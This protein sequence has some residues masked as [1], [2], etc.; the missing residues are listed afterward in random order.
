M[1]VRELHD[2]RPVAM[3]SR[4]V[5]A[6]D[7]PEFHR[8]IYL[9]EVAVFAPHMYRRDGRVMTDL[10]QCDFVLPE[11][12]LVSLSQ[13][14]IERLLHLSRVM[15][16]THRIRHHQFK[17]LQSGCVVFLGNGCCF[18]QV[19]RCHFHHH[20][21][22]LEKRLGIE[23]SDRETHLQYRLPVHK[24]RTHLFDEMAQHASLLLQVILVHVH[25]S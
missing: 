8:P 22:L 23:D 1:V 7:G 6:H 24:V 2:H 9:K 17:P 11:S 21:Y 13:D 5:S 18:L 19:V 20:G 4:R 10:L 15:S 25:Q 14:W 16:H 12:S 3:T